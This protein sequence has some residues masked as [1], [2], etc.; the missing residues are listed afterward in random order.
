MEINMSYPNPSWIHKHPKWLRAVVAEAI[1]AGRF[2]RSREWFS[3][4]SNFTA[5]NAIRE[6]APLI[7]DHWGSEDNCLV[8]EPYLKASNPRAIAA[9]E[10]LCEIFD[11]TYTISDER[12]EWFPGR[13][14]R[15]EFRRK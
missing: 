9:C 5:R 11:L 1:R 8:M 15:I 10:R 7:F 4:R 12:A 2:V 3:G 6:V 14:T 13:T